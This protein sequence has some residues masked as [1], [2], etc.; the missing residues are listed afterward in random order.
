MYK[1]QQART[2]KTVGTT[3]YYSEWSSSQ[4]VTTVSMYPGSVSI[5]A[6]KANGNGFDVTVSKASNANGY[7]IEE[8]TE[9]QLAWI[10]RDI[11][12]EAG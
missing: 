9:E 7:E 8:P 2:Y 3:T 4:E 10:M 5:T 6:V 11:P 12:G 1:R